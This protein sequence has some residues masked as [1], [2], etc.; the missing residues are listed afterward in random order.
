MGHES[1]QIKMS[2]VILEIRAGTGGDEAA[3]FAGDLARMYQRYAEK[4]G[5]KF[6]V[7]DTNKTTLHGFKTFIARASGEGALENLRQESGVHRVQRIPATEKAG[8]IHTSTASV[9]VMPVVEAR[10]VNVNPGD[11]DISFFRSSGPGGQNVNK[12]ETAVRITHKPTGI[13]VSSQASRT[14]LENRE[15]AMEVL[16]SKLFE[17]QIERQQMVMG[18]LRKEQIGTADRSEKIRTYNFPQ[19]RVTDHRIGKKFSNIE[20]ILDGDLDKIVGAF[21]KKEQEISDKQQ[22]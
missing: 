7:L 10:E 6:T 11:I 14:Q 21:A 18:S 1:P 9:A 12:V 3:I 8:R 20:K 13:V 19:D 17:A 22:V 15:Q 5:W 16:R 4:N 2:R